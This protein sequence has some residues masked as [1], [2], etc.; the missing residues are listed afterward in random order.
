LGTQ[1]ELEVGVAGW[2]RKTIQRLEGKGAHQQGE[3]S[4]PEHSYSA[5][6]A[7]GS[8]GLMDSGRRLV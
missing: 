1:E 8:S 2:L 6:V 5:A 7:V 3:S 4:P